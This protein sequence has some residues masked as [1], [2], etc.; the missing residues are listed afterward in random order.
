MSSLHPHVT[1]AQ[2]VLERLGFPKKQ[3]N[4]RSAYCLLALLDLTPEKTWSSAVENRL[5][6][7]EIMD[8]MRV[9]YGKAYAPNSRE[10]IRRQTMHQFVEA[11][12]A[13][14]NPDDPS[15]PTNSGQTCYGIEASALDLLRHFGTLDWETALGRYLAGRET[16]KEHYR[17]RREINMV[18]V[19]SEKG[20]ELQLTPGAHSELIRDI[21]EQFAPRFA[22]GARLLYAG[23]TGSKHEIYEKE[24]LAELG[25]ELSSAGKM[26][27]V[28][29]HDTNRNWLLLVEAVTSHGPV[30]PKRHGELQGLFANSTAGLVYVTA[31][32]TRGLFRTYA[33][34]IAWETEVWV[35][36]NPTHLIHFDGERFLGPYSS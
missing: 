21:I 33:A 13:V 20:E 3:T 5:G 32:P 10:T 18:A 25:V 31:F 24:A 29:F 36:D 16:L 4:E 23:D 35:A 17:R 19:V 9:N 28:V 27:D 34:D 1:E 11:S 14:L 12:L 15:R 7:T 22:P 26:P 30:D 8:W 6:I 2:A